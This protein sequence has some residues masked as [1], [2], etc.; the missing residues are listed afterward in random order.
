MRHLHYINKRDANLRSDAWDTCIIYQLTFN[1]FG[2]ITP[3]Y[4]IKLLAFK[5]PD[6]T[7]IINHGAKIN[8]D[9]TTLIRLVKIRGR[10]PYMLKGAY[11][12]LRWTK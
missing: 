3:G 11:Q 4:S 1:C 9:S 7:Q 8:H 2:L 12:S 6:P 5:F 10:Q